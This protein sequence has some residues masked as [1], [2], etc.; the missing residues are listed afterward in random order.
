MSRSYVMEW[1][2]QLC[3]RYPIAGALRHLATLNA[4]ELTALIAFVESHRALEVLAK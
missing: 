2:Q 4:S 3:A 1:A